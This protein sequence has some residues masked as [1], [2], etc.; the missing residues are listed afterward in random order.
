[1]NPSGFVTERRNLKA[2]VLTITPTVAENNRQN[3]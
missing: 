2:E 3:V 1:M